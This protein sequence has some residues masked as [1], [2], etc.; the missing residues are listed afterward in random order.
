M[1]TATMRA[2]VFARYGDP[3]VL[4]EADLPIPTRARGQVLVQVQAIGV[5]P[6]D[7]KW[8]SGMFARSR[9]LRFPH[10]PGYDIAGVVVEADAGG[11]AVGT[12]IVAML[13]PLKQGAYAQYAV[14]EA[15][16]VSTIPDLL[17]FERAAAIPTPG[18]TGVQLIEEHLDV[19][20][21]QTILLTGATG[22]VGRFA[23]HAALARGASVVAAVREKHVAAAGA[24]GASSTIVLGEASWTGPAFDHVADTVGGAAVAEL[25]RHVRPDG[26]ICSVSTTP[27]PP[28]GLPVAP[29][30][31]AVRA[32]ALR[33]SW[34][35]RAVAGGALSVDVAGIL[36]LSD[37]A[38]AQRRVEA[39]A[40]AG[41]IILS[42]D[43]VHASRI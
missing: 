18:L 43:H 29:A 15:A 13:D 39:G 26:R 2:V 33:L 5:N 7:G 37:A 41:K 28:D 22:A 38:A 6:A 16:S 36:P 19:R 30:F 31:V 12:R 25:C 40:A 24:L 14:T 1:T 9:S 4:Y 35:T 23:L 10:I 42:P 8:R 27:V 17:S 21:G 32:D 20:K 3:S 11:I 34:L